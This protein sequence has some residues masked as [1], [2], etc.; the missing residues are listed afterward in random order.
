MKKEEKKLK[1]QSEDQ[2]ELISESE[3]G[4][5]YEFFISEDKKSTIGKRA[6]KGEPREK[7]KSEMK[8]KDQ[9]ETFFL[10]DFFTDED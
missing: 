2:E 3:F 5:V 10:P 1:S 4:F 6:E 8:Y 9:S 7:R